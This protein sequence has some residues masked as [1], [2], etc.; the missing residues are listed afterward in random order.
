MNDIVWVQKVGVDFSDVV[1]M[2]GWNYK[3]FILIL[4]YI[5]INGHHEHGNKIRII[6]DKS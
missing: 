3:I 4:L 2:V 5:W 1:F 6:Y